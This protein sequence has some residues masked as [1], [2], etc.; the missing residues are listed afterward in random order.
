MSHAGLLSWCQSRTR[1]ALGVSTTLAGRLHVQDEVKLTRINCRNA[2]HGQ[3]S[4][5][6]DTCTVSGMLHC[7]AT[8]ATP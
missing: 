3:A 6:C 5:I 4:H 2:M 7:E 1:P 8:G